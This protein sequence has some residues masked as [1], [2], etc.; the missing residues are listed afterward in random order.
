[1]PYT[2]ESF[3]IVHK[4]ST[5]PDMEA[6]RKQWEA[7][8]IARQKA[9]KAKAEAAALE[10]GNAPAHAD[11]PIDINSLS[12]KERDALMANDIANWGG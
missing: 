1:M 2:Q 4:A 12:E 11:G 9:E 5:V 7:D 10:P 8:Y 3:D 6:A